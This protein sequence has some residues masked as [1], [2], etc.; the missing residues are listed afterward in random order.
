MDRQ[1]ITAGVPPQVQEIFRFQSHL[2]KRVG[3]DISLSEAIA[4]WIALGYAD[5][6]IERIHHP[7]H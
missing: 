1:Q 2:S 4:H 5:E 6:F 7:A 3:R